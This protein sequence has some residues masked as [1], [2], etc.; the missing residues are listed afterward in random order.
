MI[1][2]VF[3]DVSALSG[4]QKQFPSSQCYSHTLPGLH[5]IASISAECCTTARVPD[6]TTL[7]S[8]RLALAR[9]A[10]RPVWMVQGEAGRELR[11]VQ[12]GSFLQLCLG[13]AGRD[14]GKQG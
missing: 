7:L 12:A 13:P 10:H 14:N 8:S 5:S 9:L 3:L 2:F 6:Q 4:L 11:G 1:Q